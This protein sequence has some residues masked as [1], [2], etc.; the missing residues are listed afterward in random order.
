MIEGLLHYVRYHFI[1][2]MHPVLCYTLGVLGLM[3]P[4]S[5]WMLMQ[6]AA[7]QVIVL[8]SVIL[9]GGAAVAISY[10]A[11]WLHKKILDGQDAL[12][13]ESEVYSDLRE[14]VHAS[15]K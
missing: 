13:R 4:Y 15:G 12:E 5:A 3:L 6:G 11:D 7:H 8:W 9:S 14:T 10:F 2:K 1:P